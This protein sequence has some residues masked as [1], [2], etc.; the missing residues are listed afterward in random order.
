M[1]YIV[2]QKIEIVTGLFKL[3]I[4]LDMLVYMTSTLDGLTECG[5]TE[6]TDAFILASSVHTVLSQTS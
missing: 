4:F 6:T 1:Q 5:T 2:Q 3:H